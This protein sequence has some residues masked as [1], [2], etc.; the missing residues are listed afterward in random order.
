MSW[1][2][3]SNRFA[4]T[5][6]V[7]HHQEAATTNDFP[8]LTVTGKDHCHQRSANIWHTQL[9]TLH[10]DTKREHICMGSS[11]GLTKHVIYIYNNIQTS[12]SNIW[13]WLIT[14]FHIFMNNSHR[15]FYLKI[16]HSFGVMVPWQQ[17]QLLDPTE[18]SILRVSPL[19]YNCS[20]R[21]H[22]PMNYSATWHNAST[23]TR[24][25]HR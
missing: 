12:W 10:H 17:L 4:P 2:S 6:L 25:Q 5:Q 11:T 21:S 20:Q 1:S 18:S 8:N 13:K 15:F 22:C 14:K 3:P 24:Y 23:T 9:A 16:C 7:P 19:A